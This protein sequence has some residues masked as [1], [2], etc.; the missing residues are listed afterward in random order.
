MAEISRWLHD[1]YGDDDAPRIIQA[2]RRLD[3]NE[4]FHVILEDLRRF[5]FVYDTPIVTVPTEGQT[6]E[7]NIGRHQVFLHIVKMIEAPMPK[8][9]QQ[10]VDHRDEPRPEPADTT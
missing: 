9:K 8:P 4:D 7:S 5:C 1:Q 10:E 2:M 6:T 3:K